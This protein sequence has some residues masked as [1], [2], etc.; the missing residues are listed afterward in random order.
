MSFK[1]HIPTYS[2]EEFSAAEYKEKLYQV[3]VFDANRHFRVSYP[4][5]HDFYE[6]LFLTRG[7]GIHIIDSNEYRIEP[8]CIFFLSPGQTH[9]LDLS[10]DIQGYI[11]LFTAEF[12]LLNHSNKNRLLEFPFFYSL[13]QTNPPL[14]LNKV[15]NSSFLEQ[16]FLKG[17][18]ELIERQNCDEEVIRAIL[19]LILLTSN[20][21]YQRGSALQ[22]KSRGHILVKNFLILIDDNYQNN[23]RVQEYA[24]M[25]AITPHHLTQIVKQLTGKTSTELL[26]NKIIIEIKKLLVHTNMSMAEIVDHLNFTDQSYFTKYFKKHTGFTPLEYRKGGR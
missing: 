15:E 22:N 9:K 5:R 4:H 10:H 8:P 26:H 19:D 17:C 23:Y 1:N 2:L 21:L 3:E 16:L 6:V 24:D 14:Y 18:N 12:Y 25:L 20:K 7:S 11:F 13:E